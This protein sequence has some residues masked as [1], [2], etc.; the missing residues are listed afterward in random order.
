MNGHRERIDLTEGDLLRNLLRLAVPMILGNL[1]QNVFNLVDMIFVG[2]LGAA[3]IAAVAMSGILMT[4]VWTFLIGISIGT[5]ALVSRF[6]GAKDYARTT[7]AAN[8]A[9][10]LGLI[11]SAVL[12]ALGVLWPATPLRA[13]G[14]AEEVVRLG[15]PY[16]QTVFGG[17]VCLVLLFLIS[18]IFRGVGD[19]V[20]PVKIWA[21]S[22]V[23]NIVLD[24]LLI[25]GIGPFPRLGVLGAGVAT[26]GGQLIGLILGFLAL[27]RGYSYIRIRLRD[28]QIH[29]NLIWRLIKIAIPGSMQGFFRN[30]SGL[31]LMR[32]VAE[33][34]TPV[35]AAY[36]IGL[37]L[38]L[39]VMMPGWAI[40]SAVATLVGQNL[41]AHKPERAE[42]SGWLG[43]GMYVGL[44][45]FIGLLFYVFAA[46][47][48]RVF[49]TDP[50][51]VNTGVRY[52]RIVS[53][54]FPFLAMG[55]VPGMALGGAG[56][57]VTS[58]TVIG[59]S[60]IVFQIPAAIYLPKLGH[61][62]ADGIWI[63]VA[64]AFFLQGVL[65]TLVYR[66]GR[67]KH[68]KV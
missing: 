1:L 56:D 63:S 47:I 58:M 38:L 32:I 60:L 48:M 17:S 11:T 36:G 39:I 50:D 51:V 61:L 21:I 27:E 62:A 67:W 6:Y 3:A 55:I 14:A 20:T 13:L 64:L 31:I 34:G 37:R 65:M 52:L 23:L 2:R 40:G 16:V 12:G 57:T 43:T 54:S 53:V 66:L 42:K 29:W 46:P 59:I 22:S 41:G 28:F 33:Y 44:I 15:V 30:V 9:L 49:N 45:A 10:F 18:A 26:V 25:F 24:P 19:A 68:K 7:L 4:I 35:V 8:Q 5:T